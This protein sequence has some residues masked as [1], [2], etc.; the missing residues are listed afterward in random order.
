ARETLKMLSGKKHLV[1]TGCRLTT[2]EGLHSFATHTTVS[3][4]NLS[5]EAIDYYIENYK[6]FDKAGAYGIQEWIGYIGISGISGCY[7]NVMG[8]PIHDLFK[9][10][11][12]I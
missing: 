10:L 5:D 12:L 7:Y 6:P 9:H 8:L 2:T 11:A 4:D 3:F 1:V